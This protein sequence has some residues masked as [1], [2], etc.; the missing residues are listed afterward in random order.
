MSYCAVSMAVRDAYHSAHK[1]T[2]TSQ[3]FFRNKRGYNSIIWSCSFLCT[4]FVAKLLLR[5]TSECDAHPT[6]WQSTNFTCLLFQAEFGSQT[7]VNNESL[8]CIC[9]IEFYNNWATKHT[10]SGVTTLFTHCHENHFN[11]LKCKPV[12]AINNATIFK[13]CSH[14]AFFS[15]FY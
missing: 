12:M 14:V 11:G 9:Q 15:S 5:F 10:V 4:I 1:W 3:F 6:Q 13:E 2:D 7:Y 8:T